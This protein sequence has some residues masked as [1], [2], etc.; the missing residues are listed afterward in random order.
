MLCFIDV[1]ILFCIVEYFHFIFVSMSLFLVSIFTIVLFYLHW[2]VKVK[3]RK[4]LISWNE[5]ADVHF[6]IAWYPLLLYD[7]MEQLSLTKQNNITFF[8]YQNH[9]IFLVVLLW[10]RTWKRTRGIHCCWRV[11]F[12][13]F[14]HPSSCCQRKNW[15]VTHLKV[16]DDCLTTN[17]IINHNNVWFILNFFYYVIV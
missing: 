6:K 11:K 7:Y 13:L 15:Q 5:Q 9:W 16:Y 2:L 14:S 12:I 1:C 10:T 4:I 3:K 8:R 17:T